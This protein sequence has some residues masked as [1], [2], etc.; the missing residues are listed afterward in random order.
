MARTYVRPPTRSS[1]RTTRP[2]AP[3]RSGGGFR[4]PSIRL[5]LGKLVRPLAMALAVVL[6]VLAAMGFLL[7]GAFV[8]L[9]YALRTVVS[10]LGLGAAL[11]LPAVAVLAWRGHVLGKGGLLRQH[12]NHLLGGAALYCGMLAVARSQGPRLLRRLLV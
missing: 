12:W 5:N 1:S 4:L 9:P 7:F 6:G 11:P 3:R 8:A 10:L 2:P